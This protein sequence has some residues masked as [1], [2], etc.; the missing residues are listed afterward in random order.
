MF[1]TIWL[2]SIQN[3]LNAQIRLKLEGIPM[4]RIALLAVA[5]ALA[6]AFAVTRAHAEAL[7]ITMSLC[8]VY[9][10]DCSTTELIPDGRVRIF[11]SGPEL[12][13]NDPENNLRWTA[14]CRG[15]L[16]A[17]TPLPSTRVTCSGQATGL[18]CNTP[19]GSTS[20][21]QESVSP[22]GKVAM[23]C[24]GTGSSILP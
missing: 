10:G 24:Q 6:A 20:N 2:V 12:P 3:G 9:A 14:T 1:L 4:K 15:T 13:N 21:W 19:A 18:T 11:A 8:T 7:T 17:G 23:V 22:D 5:V 16:P